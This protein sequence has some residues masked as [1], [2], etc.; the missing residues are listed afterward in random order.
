M[1]SC[2]AFL[3]MTRHNS[4]GVLQGFPFPISL[5]ITAG[6][7]RGPC[8]EVSHPA[9]VAE[10]GH[11]RHTIHFVQFRFVLFLFPT[12]T[13]TRS[14]I[15]FLTKPF[16]HTFQG[17]KIHCKILVVSMKLLLQLL[18]NTQ[19]LGRNIV[20]LQ[21]FKRCEFALTCGDDCNPTRTSLLSALRSSICGSRRAAS[22]KHCPPTLSAGQT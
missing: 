14:N 1:V 5:S 22:P 19:D 6:P 10:F 8:S 12:N 13:C 2:S 18:I 4:F 20:L 15:H 7:A 17:G 21:L 9:S 3:V 11:T 16:V